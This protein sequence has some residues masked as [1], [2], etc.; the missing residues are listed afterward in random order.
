[1]DTALA[2]AMGEAHKNDPLMVFDWDK[3]A[4]ILSERMPDKAFAGLEGDFE[5]TGGIIW[6]SGEPYMRDY[7][8]LASTW[9]KPLLVI[10]DEEIECWMY[11]RDSPD[12]GADTKWPKSAR[13]TVK[14]VKEDKEGQ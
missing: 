6:L 11:Q 9:A 5:Y 14:K 4:H 7:T 2:F 8:Y 1:M 10:G 12:W 3:A 13:E